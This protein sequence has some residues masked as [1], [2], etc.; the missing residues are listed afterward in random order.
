MSTS[1]DTS[2]I[3]SYL[4]N[5]IAYTTKL[6]A[7]PFTILSTK[8]ARITSI[9]T[10][11]FLLN[12]DWPIS[13]ISLISKSYWRIMIESYTLT[14]LWEMAWVRPSTILYRVKKGKY[15]PIKIKNYRSWKNNKRKYM[16]KYILPSDVLDFINNKWK[17]NL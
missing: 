1:E 5:P 2:N 4:Y 9:I 8:L 11:G 16:I 6:V 14:E 17:K 12:K 10:G 15:I 13:R 7:T 3:Y